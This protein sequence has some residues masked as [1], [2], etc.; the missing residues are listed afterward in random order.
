MKIQKFISLIV[1]CGLLLGACQSSAPTPASP[2]STPPQVETA[3]PPTEQPAGPT[4][5]S[6]PTPTEALP[7]YKDTTASLDVRVADLLSRMTLEEKIGQMTQI[8][9]NSLGQ[10]DIA[11]Y[12]L[13]SV[14]S[15]GGGSPSKNDVAHWAAMVNAFQDEALSTR[16]GIPMLYGVDAI[17][18]HGNLYGAT[19]FPQNIGL[20]ATN[21]PDLVYR[22][23][24][25]TAAEMAATSIF[26]N[27]A[28]VVAVP[29]DIRWGRT[30]EGY[31]ENTDIVTS[32]GEAYIRGLQEPTL[33]GDDPI[34]YVVL[35]TPKHYIGDGGTTWGT[36]T[37]GGYMLDQGVTE[38]DEAQL[39]ALFLPPYQAAIDSGALIIMNSFSS[40]GGTKMSANKY[41]LT[42]VLK[43][44]LGFEGFI[45]SDW[46]SIDQVTPDYYQ[47]N[48][49]S[50]NAGIDM[51]MAPYDAA[52]FISTIKKAVDNGD[53]SLER[54]DDAVRRILY[55]KFA[56]G[57]FEHP[58]ADSSLFELVGSDEHRALAREAVAKSLVLLKNENGALP[59]AKDTPLIFVAGKGANDIGTQCGGWTIQWQGLPGKIT[60]GLTI[61]DAINIT[62]ANPDNVHYNQFGKFDDLV[63]ANGSPLIADVGIVVVG[64]KPYAEGQGDARNLDL[65]TDQIDMLERMR[66][67]VH[68][69]IVIIISGRPL[70][71]TDQL[72]LADAWV[73]AWLPGT[74]ALGITDVLFGDVAFTG[75]LPYTWPSSYDQ[76][77]L[78]LNN[79]AESGQE[80]LF[81]FGYGICP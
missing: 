2:S 48:V 74:E 15:G 41:L 79:Q 32:L 81:E 12:L 64:E 67:S 40:W 23:G 4:S 38:Y 33:L 47:A 37:S 69:L 24:K 13:G 28:P 44:E 34:P 43:T 9:K 30:Y 1:I 46:A 77:P 39:R 42:T 45:V 21:D 70:I 29:Q 54:I 26:W 73:A 53:I 68:T 11:K 57:L 75:K 18:G 80:P 49:D 78:N 16:L 7:I 5:T 52:R 20:G 61:L 50:I 58:Y 72:E 66:Q 55:V 36:S 65:P 31:S 71:I 17:H 3:Q 51:S 25:A 63:D 10:G 60:P 35:A 8:E 56:L 14:L 76:L 22:I 6:A 59:L 62:V 27:F 19:I